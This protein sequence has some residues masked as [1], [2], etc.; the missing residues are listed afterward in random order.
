MPS[1][2]YILHSCQPSAVQPTRVPV[3]ALIT[4][5]MRP[6]Q[7]HF[8]CPLLP[9]CLT[10]II[11]TTITSMTILA[12]TSYQHYQCHHQKVEDERERVHI[13][14]L[15]GSHNLSDTLRILLPTF[16]TLQYLSQLLGDPSG[17]DC[18]ILF[19]TFDT[20]A[21]FVVLC[22]DSQTTEILFL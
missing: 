1:A 12:I 15:S 20:F 7:S 4:L 14:P 16:Y 9:N 19:H 22:F 3:S 17:P 2:A 18:W 8:C 10:I 6:N 13:W 5:F 11:T 21:N